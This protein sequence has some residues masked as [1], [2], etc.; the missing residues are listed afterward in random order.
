MC[1][2]F[3][4]E[5][6]GYNLL[7]HAA[8]A[9]AR[10]SFVFPLRMFCDAEPQL[11]LMPANIRPLKTAKR[12]LRSAIAFVSMKSIAPNNNHRS[13]PFRANIRDMENMGAMSEALV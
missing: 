4:K 8:C 6:S 11:A 1:L 9:D 2:F 7:P 13:E 3:L 5:L 12:E 10:L